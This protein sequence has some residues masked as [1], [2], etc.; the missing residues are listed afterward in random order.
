MGHFYANLIELLC[1]YVLNIIYTDMITATQLDTQKTNTQIIRATHLKHFQLKR[2]FCYI[3]K[4]DEPKEEA[5]HTH[6]Q[7]E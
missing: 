3:F 7:N 6:T 4:F 5:K 1:F 2:K